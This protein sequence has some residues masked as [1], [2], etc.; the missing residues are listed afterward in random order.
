M[1]NTMNHTAA[2][3]CCPAPAASA[4]ASC[5]GPAASP[6]PQRVAARLARLGADIDKPA[7]AAA[8]IALGIALF[9]PRQLGPS[10]S[11]TLESVINIL[12]WLALSVAL[13]AYAKA[14][15][16]DTLIAHAFTGSPLR[17]IAVGALL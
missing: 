8:L 9:A 16:A 1:M 7:A 13:A 17:M 3:G 2:V 11:F 15:R 10:M 12:P 4:P 6:L 14:S 5:C